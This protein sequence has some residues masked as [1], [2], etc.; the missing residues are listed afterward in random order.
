MTSLTNGECELDRKSDISVDLPRY[1]VEHPDVIRVSGGTHGEH[2]SAAR[3]DET[4]CLT[5]TVAG[6]EDSRVLPELVGRKMVELEDLNS[7][8]TNVT[9][10]VSVVEHAETEKVRYEEASV[11]PDVDLESRLSVV[12]TDYLPLSREGPSLAVQDTGVEH[13]TT[14]YE[15]I[16]EISSGE[17]RGDAEATIKRAG[18]DFDSLYSKL[19]E[20]AVHELPEALG[21]ETASAL[22]YGFKIG[23]MVWGKVKSHPWWPGHIFSVAFASPSVRWTKREGHVLVA[24]FGDSS[25]GWFD[26]AEL[27]PFDPHYAEK[28]RQTNSRNFLKAVEEAVDEACRRRALALACYCRNPFNFRPANVQGYFSVDVG[29]YEPGGVYSVKQ[30]EMAR[31]SFH[32][33]EMLS[34]VLRMALT[35]RNDEQKGIDWIKD[36]ALVLAYRKA[37]FEEYDETYAQAFGVQTIRS[38]DTSGVLYQPEKVPSRAPLSGPLV[39]AEA[40]GERKSSTKLIKGKDQSKKDK[41]LL[42]R[43]EGPNDPKSHHV[44][45]GPVGISVPSSLKKGVAAP[46]AGDYVL[47]KRESMKPLTPRKVAAGMISGVISVPS[48]GAAEQEGIQVAA[49]RPIVAPKGSVDSAVNTSQVSELAGSQLSLPAAGGSAPLAQGGQEYGKQPLDEDMCGLQEVKGRVSVDVVGGGPISA[50]MNLSN[51]GGMSEHRGAVHRDF[52]QGGAA[53]VDAKHE[54]QLIVGRTVEVLEQAKMRIAKPSKDHN[55][56]DSVWE[57]ASGL[58]LLAADVKHPASK[59]VNTGSD[60]GMKAKNVR[61]H[62][63][64]ELNF[65]KSIMRER[66]K[67]KKKELG[68]EASLDHKQKYLKIQKDGEPV[69]KSAGKSIGIGMVSQKKVDGAND[70]FPS[71][72]LM[73]PSVD[74]GDADV[75]LPQLVDDLLALALD[76]FHGVERNSP[77]I[78][79]Q[80]LLRF[81]SIVY[82]KSLV[83][84]PLTEAETSDQGNKSSAVTGGLDIPPGD[85]RNQPSDS[86]PPK[87]LFRSDDLTKAGRKRNPSDRQE[88]ISAKR[89]K[90][91]KELKA[92]TME[93][94]SGSLNISEMQRDRKDIKDTGV[95]VPA[96]PIKADSVKKLEPS[97][98]VAE[99]T[100]LVIKFPPKTTLP[101]IPELKARFV[102]FGQLDHSAIR[103]L[104]K[105]STCRVVF[106][107]KSHAHAA[108]NHAIRNSSLFGNVKV[109][110]YLRDL[111]TP[112]QESFDLVRRREDTADET[113]QLK[114]PS[115]NNSAGEPRQAAFLPRLPQPAVQP[116]SILK[117]PNGDEAGPIVGVSRDSPRVKFMLG[118]EESSRGEQLVIS[119]SVNNNGSNADG[120]ASSLAM[121]VYSKNFQKVISPLPPLLPLPPRSSLDARESPAV[122]QLPKF[123][124]LHHSEVE[125]RNNH[126]YFV[127]TTTTITISATNI[128]ISHQMLNLLMRC[129]DIVTDVKSSLGYVPYHPL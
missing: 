129:S 36:K 43:R 64:D 121:G 31:D 3:I 51:T 84:L 122:G 22:R 6:L 88:E 109:K 30:I 111:E 113:T 34:F 65:E 54:E 123:H 103:V 32:P 114:V 73:T 110:Y 83:L 4:E 80:I 104:W 66:K 81:R 86:R 55:G 120:G 33:D 126:N 19:D 117:K 46:V 77:A 29:G 24:F 18:S 56:L 90:K 63:G 27:I 52:W 50:G 74:M 128:D 101:S 47:Q 21:A 25:Y 124:Y 98:R 45:Q 87:H 20:N 118:G 69:R 58:P 108:Y 127:P 60:T 78:V 42:K 48:Q 5:T 7:N 94:K 95:G 23:D 1:E 8:G 61:K 40:L 85:E 100:M 107:H 97:V 67:K 116:K 26:P 37:V 49:K 92:L 35:P 2:R 68:S 112:A 99:P 82:Q 44:S 39:I 28:S 62:P 59:V 11:S 14:R 53:M 16:P 93:K 102:R 79:R 38:R 91:L 15:V 41:Y 10:V 72:S 75:D 89:L 119:S 71:S 13:A 76:P 70:S 17:T 105:S 125:M 106:K 96:K 9:N 57:G 115:T 12:Q